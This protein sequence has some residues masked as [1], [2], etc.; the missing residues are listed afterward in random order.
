MGTKI[1]WDTYEGDFAQDEE[2]QQFD[3]IQ[4]KLTELVRH[5]ETWADDP[6]SAQG[7]ASIAKVREC[8]EHVMAA[9]FGM[10]Y[11]PKREIQRLENFY[12]PIAHHWLAALNGEQDSR[13]T[14]QQGRNVEQALDDLRRLRD[15]WVQ[16]Y[17]YSR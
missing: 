1:K 3:T 9:F 7:G 10:N 8:K 12:S 17:E 16:I 2:V 6:D 15:E 4:H 14:F 13:L 11:H 5:A